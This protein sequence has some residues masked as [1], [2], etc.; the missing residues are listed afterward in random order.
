MVEDEEEH[1]LILE[2]LKRLFSAFIKR[3]VRVAA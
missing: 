3:S 1:F 2:A